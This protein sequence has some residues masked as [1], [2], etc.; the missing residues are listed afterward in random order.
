MGLLVTFLLVL[1]AILLPVATAYVNITT[2][3]TPYG[4]FN[5]GQ[6]PRGRGTFGIGMSS[7]VTFFFCIWTAIHPDIV[8]GASATDRVVY[9]TILMI[10]SILVPEGPAVSAF[11]QWREANVLLAAWRLKMGYPKTTWTARLQFWTTDDNDGFGL[12]G[13][14]F[15]VMGGFVVDLHPPNKTTAGVVP[16]RPQTTTLTSYG[17]L[18]YLDEGYIHRSTFLKESINDKSQSSAISKSL[19]GLQA[20]WFMVQ[21]V[22]RWSVGLTLTLLE[23]HVAIQVLCTAVLYVFWW[24]KPLDV[25]TP[26][27]IVLQMG[28]SGDHSLPVIPNFS[29]S[30]LELEQN[31]SDDE[32]LSGSLATQSFITRR[33]PFGIPGLLSKASHDL[34][35]H[36]T[37]LRIGLVEEERKSSTSAM[38]LE[39]ALVIG[40]GVLHAAAWNSTFPTVIEGWLWRGA[41]LSIC[42]LPVPIVYLVLLNGYHDDLNMVLWKLQLTEYNVF[43][44]FHTWG[45]EIVS[46]CRRHAVKTDSHRLIN[47]IWVQAIMIPYT[48]LLIGGYCW[49]VIFLT[50]ESYICLR[51]LPADSFMTPRWINYWPHI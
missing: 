45:I 28:V 12:E 26:I 27:K 50:V 32:L 41:S 20:M 22:S 42:I 13:A 19:A 34:A 38:A 44:W 48:L 9:K 47:K 5:I 24:W 49:A 14:F 3:D 7:T 11:G 16:P 36:V 18:K 17:F 39:G 43:T 23:I 4:K 15:V 6:E 40:S 51:D 25:S 33:S 35:M 21:C 10:I 30:D 31:K 37:K 46:A 29:I 2:Y 1:F 8:A